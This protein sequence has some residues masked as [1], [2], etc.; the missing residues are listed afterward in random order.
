[1][2]NYFNNPKIP[3]AARQCLLSLG[4]SFQH[5]QCIAAV[6]PSE[7]PSV[8]ALNPIESEGAIKIP[9]CHKKPL[10]RVDA[11][12]LLANMK[13][14]PA[15]HCFSVCTRLSASLERVKQKNCPT[16]QEVL[17]FYCLHFHRGS[18]LSGIR[19]RFTN[20]DREM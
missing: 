16:E 4:L 17:N 10:R 13:R 18:H 9:S 20:L 15:P 2:P 6:L 8:S 11:G 12:R 5:L 7:D 19:G 3:S 14:S 1:M